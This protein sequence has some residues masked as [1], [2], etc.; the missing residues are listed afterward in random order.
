M[1]TRFLKKCFQTSK[2]APE[3]FKPGVKL[4]NLPSNNRPLHAFQ[5]EIACYICIVT[6]IKLS[7]S[8]QDL[9]KASSTFSSVVLKT[10]ARGGT[11]KQRIKLLLSPKEISIFLISCFMQIDYL[12]IQRQKHA[13]IS[14]CP[15]PKDKT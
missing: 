12:G 13:Y 9:Q 3:E 15:I 6:S 14:L 2:Q 8:N 7:W 11:E 4:H 1:Q 10:G 5:N